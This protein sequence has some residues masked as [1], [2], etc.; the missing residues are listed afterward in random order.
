MQRQIATQV[1]SSMKLFRTAQMSERRSHQSIKE[2]E[3]LRQ[4]PVKDFA[5]WYSKGDAGETRVFLQK[6]GCTDTSEIRFSAQYPKRLPEEFTNM[7]VTSLR[8]YL[9]SLKAQNQSL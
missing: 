8:Q 3:C 6:I 2:I 1:Q 5:T 4:R 7:D 9:E